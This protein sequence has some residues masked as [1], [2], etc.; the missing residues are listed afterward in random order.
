MDRL[1]LL[2]CGD[3]DPKGMFICHKPHKL[4]IHIY[5]L[6]RQPS[7]QGKISVAG[8]NIGMIV[9]VSQHIIGDHR[10]PFLFRNH[11]YPFLYL[12]VFTIEADSK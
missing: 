10:I 2:L 9:K 8:N 11:G 3:Y 6:G 1:I 5:L 12:L 4:P 7:L